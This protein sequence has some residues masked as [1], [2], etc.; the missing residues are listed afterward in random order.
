MHTSPTPTAKLLTT[1]LLLFTTAAVTAGCG[2]DK[3]G[4]PGPR[5]RESAVAPP[6][7]QARARQVADAWDGSHVAATWLRGYHPLAPALQ[8]PTTP[9]RND[10]DRH[11][12]EIG[13]FDVR[14]N[15][16]TA[17]SK[18]AQVTWPRGGALTL[19]VLGAGE[20]YRSFDRATT[21][22]PHLI[23]TGAKLGTMTLATSRGPANV[24]AWLFTIKGYDTP[25]KRA[26]VRPSTL[27]ESPIGPARNLPSD[28]L[29][30]LGGLSE[31]SGDGR[32]VT[33][34]AGHGSCDD[35]PAVHALETNGSV[36]L[37]AYVVGSTD[38]ACTSDLRVEEVTVRLARP[39]TG[40]ILLDA[41]TGRPVEYGDGPGNSSPARWG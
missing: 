40:R 38:G 3:P 16:P 10:S 21:P 5:T 27:P 24:S 25:L 23:V 14:G 32:T 7:A 6:Q 34:S 8:P 2:S 39:L 20:A 28:V 26:A 22:G 31:V 30:P 19:P 33:V 12:Y 9:P 13:D 37:A 1:A 17:P 11:A 36:V 41:S 35:G 18:D 4:A 15:F 29:S